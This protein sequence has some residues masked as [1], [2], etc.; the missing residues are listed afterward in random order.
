MLLTEEDIKKLKALIS[1][2]ESAVPYI[3]A[4]IK[5]DGGNTFPAAAGPD[6]VEVHKGRAG[7]SVNQLR[8]ILAAAKDLKKSLP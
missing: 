1:S 8:V 7:S 6:W 5:P 2:I 3:E 4:T